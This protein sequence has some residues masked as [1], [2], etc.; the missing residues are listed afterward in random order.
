M[1]EFTKYI[2]CRPATLT[3]NPV[4]LRRLGTGK[5][6]NHPIGN[7]TKHSR[8]VHT[9]KKSM[10]IVLHKYTCCRLV[11]KKRGGHLESSSGPR[12]CDLRRVVI[13]PLPWNYSEQ[14]HW[15]TLLGQR[16]KGGRGTDIASNPGSP[17]QILSRSF[18]FFSKAARQNP[19]RR[20]Q[21]R[22][23]ECG[24]TQEITEMKQEASMS[25]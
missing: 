23:T 4:A 2:I 16:R 14:L 5:S 19:E 21:E 15:F 17:F 18:R 25:L 3:A 7:S 11:R 10:S 8:N 6:I 1:A 22:G 20:A 9:Y 12:Y 24:F 13:W